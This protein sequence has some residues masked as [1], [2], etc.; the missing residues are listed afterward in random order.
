MRGFFRLITAFCRSA[1]P[2]SSIDSVAFGGFLAKLSGPSL[3]SFRN[4]SRVW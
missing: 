1:C 2:T 4:S 3:H